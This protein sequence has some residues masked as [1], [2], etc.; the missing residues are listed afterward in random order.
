MVA[1]LSVFGKLSQIGNFEQCIWEKK[2]LFAIGNDSL[3]TGVGF[4]AKKIT[5]HNT[6]YLRIC[7]YAQNKQHKLKCMC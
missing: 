1:V 4:I 3:K 6:I 2:I 7:M 5:D